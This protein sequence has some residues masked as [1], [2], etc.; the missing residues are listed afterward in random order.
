MSI[1]IHAGAGYHS[2][3]NESVHLAM[4][5]K[6]ATRGMECLRA[7]R[8]AVEAVEAAIMVLEDNEIT[9][10]GLGSNLT[11]N[12]I[13]ECD[14]TIVD[15]HGR[16][17]ACGAV[18]NIKNPISLARLILDTSTEAL[19]LRRVPP[20]FLVGEGAK[21]FAIEHGMPTV[22]NSKLIS[23]NAEDRYKRWLSDLERAHSMVS[24][25]PVASPKAGVSQRND[26][27]ARSVEH[28]IVGDKAKKGLLRDHASAIMASTWNEGQPDSPSPESKLSLAAS[29]SSHLLTPTK[30][31]SPLSGADNDLRFDALVDTWPVAKRV[32]TALVEQSHLNGGSIPLAPQTKS[33][34]DV[35]AAGDGSLDANSM[36]EP[37]PSSGTSTSPPLTHKKYAVTELA[38]EPSP[39][40]LDLITDTMGAIAID[41]W[42]NI[43]GGSS[44]GGIGMK[45][46]GRTG[47]AALVGIGTAVVP[48]NAADPEQ[49]TVAAVTS[50]TGE[51]MATT[52]AASKCA[53]RLYHGT[54]QG[55]T[56]RDIHDCDS[57]D[58]MKSFVEKDFMNHPG[59]RGQSSIR[60][61]GV[62]A[63]E[64]TK[65]GVYLHWAHNTD[66]FALA[67][68]GSDDREPQTCM[69]R[70][71]ENA[72]V[73]VGA[74]KINKTKPK[75][76]C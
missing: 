75:T 17:G 53:E 4:C 8:T 73:N 19:T 31:R 27:Q 18:P 34:A 33:N 23:R 9:N 74:R 70:L 28:S 69:S 66:S 48:V 25:T 16:G 41:Q 10:A 36:P 40:D 11:I 57:A 30:I 72:T 39:A 55:P 64:V 49:K 71:P 50:G 32:K 1:F 60:A 5:S 54:K 56:G 76:I 68:F 26:W 63:V 22:A 6:A 44:S 3:Q 62:M 58:I 7:G 42:G 45:H 15:H 59:V 46:C 51:H 65:S 24:A 52:M 35:P 12:G 29:R 61:I 47:P 43:A 67:S 20:N 13:V 2:L 37:L 38:T 14:A 21:S